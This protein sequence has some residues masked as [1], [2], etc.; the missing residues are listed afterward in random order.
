ML[1]YKPVEEKE[2]LHVK[3]AMALLGKDDERLGRRMLRRFR[4]YKKNQEL[5]E[6]GIY[7]LGGEIFSAVTHG[8]T[9]LVGVAVLVLSVIFAVQSGRGALA[10]A[11]VSIFGVCVM[12][13]F[14]IS[15]IY[16]SLA[17]NAGKRV[18]RVLDHCSIYFIIAGTYTPFAL[19]A[20]EGWLG[21]TIFG[22][23]WALAI[24]GCTLSAINFKKFKT[25]EFIC[26]LTMGWVGAVGLV[27]MVGNIGFGVSFWLLLGGGVAY[28][29]GAILFKVKGKYIHGVWH[30]FT[31]V[32]LVCHFLSIVF[33][34]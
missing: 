19:L 33:F 9:A 6:Q 24:V 34:L 14:T 2:D 11:S 31:L 21:W 18:M 32:G 26:Y 3:T 20:I 16:H 27:T 4:S 7:S 23:N 17:I 13:G 5:R 30:L 15:T 25:F 1:I 10:I 8:V 12:V 28:T 22:V 29:I